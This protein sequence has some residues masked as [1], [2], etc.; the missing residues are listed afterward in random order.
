MVYGILLSLFCIWTI[1]HTDDDLIEGRNRILC[2]Q[3]NHSYEINLVLITLVY[4]YAVIRSIYCSWRPNIQF[5]GLIWTCFVYRFSNSI[6]INGLQ[7]IIETKTHSLLS[8]PIRF[9]RRDNFKQHTYV[10]LNHGY[11]NVFSHNSWYLSW[12]L[13]I[14][15]FKREFVLYWNVF[16]SRIFRMH[17][18]LFNI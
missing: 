3:L 12:I 11:S 18:L 15:T 9:R 14:R 10:Q 4:I 5:N 17:F 8:L 6:L 13:S 1:V 2:H 7:K 16:N